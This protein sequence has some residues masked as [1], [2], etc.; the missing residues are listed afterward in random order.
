MKKSRIKDISLAKEGALKIDWAEA[1][2]PVLM[3]L[4]QKFSGEKPFKNW[5][6]AACLHIT[7]E[8]AVLVRTLAAGGAQIAITAC[9]PLSTQ[10]DIA[11][12]LALEGFYVYGWRGLNNNEYYE[13]IEITLDLKPDIT[14]D[15]ACDLIFTAHTKRQELLPNIKG[16]CEETTSGVKRLKIMEGEGVLKYPVIAVNSARTKHLFDNRYGTGQSSFDGILRATNILI[17]GKTV[18]VVGYGWCGRGISARAKGFGANVVI[19]EV[20]PIAALEARM[21]GFMVMP[22]FEAAKIG[23]IFVTATGNKYVIAEEHFKL[24]KTGAILANA[25]HFNIEIDVISLEKLSRKKRTIRPNCVEYTLAHGKRLYL[26]SEGRLV[27][28]SSAEGHPSEVMDMSFSTQAL[29]SLFIV[30]NHKDLKPG[31]YEFSKEDE[32]KIA[33]LKLEAMG[34]KID[35]LTSVQKKY[36]S[37]WQEGTR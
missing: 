34:I 20:E 9:N 37:S 7:K 32:Q 16:G 10:D 30:R 29:A 35:S 2:M 5:R 22:I 28:L 13:N 18:V 27:N 14:I 33:L 12:S 1:H 3:K 6:I 31:V 24:M 36:L 26:L 11:A 23:D 15:D 25:G 21:D 4:R 19:T 17:A 8:T